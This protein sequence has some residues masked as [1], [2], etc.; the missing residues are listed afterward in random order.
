[1]P[2]QDVVKVYAFRVFGSHVE[3]PRLANF[4]ATRETIRRLE[5]EL[6]PG[7]EQAVSRSEL[8]SDGRYRRIA[9]GWGGLNQR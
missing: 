2:D 6:V 7:T 5:G 8:D 4:K 1:M 9:T 3:S